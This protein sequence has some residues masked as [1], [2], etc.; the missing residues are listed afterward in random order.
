MNLTT[1][2]EIPSH[3]TPHGYAMS[4]KVCDRVARLVAWVLNRKRPTLKPVTGLEHVPEGDIFVFNHFTRVETIV[5]S[6]LLYRTTGSF[7]R[8][9][10]QGSLFNVNK[11]L[12]TILRAVGAVPHNMDNLLAFL[13][14]EVLRGHKVVIFPEGGMVKDRRVQD[15]LSGFGLF[16]LKNKFERKHH[17]GA[18]VLA[19]VLDLFKQHLL[20]LEAAGDSQR[21]DQW[22]AAL[23]IHRLDD[24]LARAHKPT[25]IVPGNITYFPIRT[26]ANLFSWLANILAERWW[27]Q[28]APEQM[29]E[30]LVIEGNIL[31]RTTDMDITFSA[32]LT[33]LE[34][35]SA[36]EK[37]MVKQALA[38]LTSLHELFKLRESTTPEAKRLQK[39]VSHHSEALRESYMQ[40][41]YNHTTINMNH[42][43]ATA[44]SV[45]LAR[46]QFSIPHRQLHLILY[47]A[48]KHLQSN[49]DVSFHCSVTLPWLYSG[50][51]LGNCKSFT[52]FLE[53]CR[54]ARLVKK[55]DDNY[56]LSHRLEDEFEM[57]DIRLENPV[58]L[59]A[60]EAATVPA[61]R[62]AIDAAFKEVESLKPGEQPAGLPELLF[63]DLLQDYHFKWAHYV[64][65]D[66]TLCPTLEDPTIAAPYLLRPTQKGR[67][68]KHAKAKLA[69]V[70]IHGFS[71]HAGELKQFGE[72]LHQL[73]HAVIGVRIPG[74]GTT[75]VDLERRTRHDWLANLHA[76]MRLASTVGEKVAV[77]GFSTGGMLALNVAATGQHPALVGV[78]CVSAPAV[79]KNKR[80]Y[81]LPFVMPLVHFLRWAT[82]LENHPR[83]LRFYPTFDSDGIAYSLRPL[84]SL[85]QLR[86]L[87]N[88][89]LSQLQHVTQPTLILQGTADETVETRSAEIIA[90]GLT[91]S[92][93]EKHYIKDGRH[94]LITYAI[95]NTIPLITNFLN[96]LTDTPSIPPNNK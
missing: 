28:S 50:L 78:A 37:T 55:M 34:G 3:A 61:V 4:R 86:L 38:H 25:Q 13:A 35:L 19:V 1:P 96:S 79:V 23:G 16:S 2:P 29:L 45:L 67:G 85:N 80:L 88:E 20:A 32:P 31:F 27:K 18:A 82:P 22:R 51:E 48:L 6:F 62:Q 58:A 89:T 87:T 72:Q 81:I 66:P 94:R 95:G 91:N 47:L 69:V 49:P 33:A 36:R 65:K 14:A 75:P 10:A 68:A 9:V 40:A 43:V 53:V 52:G 84:V 60:N 26:G 73:G 30:E 11:K 39:L 21:L 46:R 15:S 59:H 76:A 63:S 77:V 17:R 7:V 5:T 57:H 74:H 56:R 70:L 12:S 54:R 8:S 90:N 71:A 41:I 42:L 44:F 93:V 64:S 83:M 92:A 24:L